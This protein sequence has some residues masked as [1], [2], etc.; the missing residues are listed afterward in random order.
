MPHTPPTNDNTN[1]DDVNNKTAFDKAR[2]ELEKERLKLA[3]KKLEVAENLDRARLD[4]EK[5]KL[6]VDRSIG[7]VQKGRGVQ[8]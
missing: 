2:L 7:D 6:A 5:G 8:S 3:K 4:I 1:E